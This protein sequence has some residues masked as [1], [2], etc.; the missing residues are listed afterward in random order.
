MI[1]GPVA[2]CGLSDDLLEA[3]LPSQVDADDLNNPANATFL[4]NGVVGSFECAFAGYAMASGILGWELEDSWGFPGPGPETK[5]RNLTTNGFAALVQGCGGIGVSVPLSKA[6]FQ[7]DDMIGRLNA[8][9]D[10]QVANRAQLIAKVTAYSAYTRVL[11]GEAMC[12]IAFDTGGELQPSD[13]FQQAESLFTIVLGG[14][15]T[16]DILGMAQVGRAR[17]RLDLGKYP[18]AAAD[19]ATVPDGF[20]KNATRSASDATRENNLVRQNNMANNWTVGVRYQGLQFQGVP[21]P[22]VPVTNTGIPGRDGQTPLWVQ[23][24]Y[25]ALS[26]PIPIAR[27]A[28]AQLILAETDWR[29]GNDAGAVDIINVLHART[30]PPLPPFASTDHAEIWNQ[31]LYERSA[32]LFQES[33]QLGDIRRLGL[34]LFPAPGTVDAIHGGTFLDATCFPLLD[35]ERENNPNLSVRRAQ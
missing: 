31:I 16:A 24:K 34:P 19:A 11:L 18:E 10:D 32:E 7:A 5:H 8:W 33:Q 3:D 23:N 20:V 28:E 27:W 13:V 12:T 4:V 26:T 30:N 6:R 17:A 35:V 21:D 25:P 2:G 14:S 22:R 29:A 1:L 9:T 15:P